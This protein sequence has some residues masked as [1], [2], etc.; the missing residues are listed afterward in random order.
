VLAR[1]SGRPI[2]PIAIAT[3]RRFAAKSWD[4]ASIDLPFASGGAV[5]A[6]PVRVAMDADDAELEAARRLVQERLNA[7]TARA[8]KLAG[9]A[10]GESGHD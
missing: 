9:R 10:S 2:Y 4:K 6:E 7:A 8:E 3:N 5:A 1:Y